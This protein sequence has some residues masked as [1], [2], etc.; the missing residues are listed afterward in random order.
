[1]D[2][3]FLGTTGLRVS[4]LCFGA[5]LFGE[6]I[7]EK[8]SHELLDGFVDAG[9]TFIDTSNN[10][11]RGVSEQ[12]L[13]R[14]LTRQRREDLVIATK[15]RGR[16]SD[17]P[18]DE[19]LSRQHIMKSVD[20]SLRRLRTDYLDLYQIHYWDPDTPIAE[21]LSTMD[22]LVRSGKVRYVG[23]CSVKGYQLQKA[24]GVADK[25]GWE[26]FVSLQPCY[27][28][29]VREPEWELIALCR[30][31]GLGVLPFSPL[32]KGWLSGRYRRD[33]AEPPS[34]SRIAAAGGRMR[35]AEYGT[36]HTWAVL[37]VLHEVSAETG[38][39]PAQVALN[40][41]LD[42][43]GVTAPI[44][45]VRTREQLD[46]NLGA[47]GWSLDAEQRARLDKA[48]SRPAPYPYSWVPD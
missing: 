48:S 21:T 38:R 19:G 20:E 32:A 41:L 12:I 16:M 25:H 37:D 44:I 6:V 29:L 24:L 2:N 18:T 23:A 17:A 34:D 27:N 33:R 47:V 45:G 22:T 30:K 5:M 26:P 9:G 43:P 15:V 28:L 10:Y 11:S 3:R 1:V 42:A 8:V 39:T 14:W 36:E 40:W 46:D 13:G 7:D 35:W 31:E 4:E